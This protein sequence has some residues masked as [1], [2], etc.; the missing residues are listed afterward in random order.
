MQSKELIFVKPDA[1]ERKLVGKIISRFEEAGFKLLKVKK[2]ML[3]KELVEL[4]YPNSEEQI[5]GMGNKSLAS[6]TQ[7]SGIDAV[8]KLFGTTEPLE[9]GKILNSWN[10][11]YA[12]SGEV[13]ACI[14]EAD[15]AASR[16]R[17]L[18]GATD[19][20]KADKGT[21]RGDYGEDSIYAANTSKRACKTLVHASDSDRAAADVANFEKY[22]F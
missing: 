1:I 3:S 19:P 15:D 11:Q 8:M 2:A 5:G 10:R 14:I 20:S 6:M 17:L 22:F 9:I 13:I 16:A 4:L 12:V 7:K 21:I 18:V